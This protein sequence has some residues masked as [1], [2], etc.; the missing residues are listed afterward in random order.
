MGS[1]PGFRILTLSAFVSIN[2]DDDEEGV[3]GELVNGVWMPFIGADPD[4]VASL[5]PRAEAIAKAAGRDVELVR[6][7]V[8]ESLEVIHGGD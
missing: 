6:F 2:P 4:R 1:R 5:R 7:S 8:R 3:L